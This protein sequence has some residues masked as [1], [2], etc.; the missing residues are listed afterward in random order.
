MYE[1]FT[2]K[3]LYL[4]YNIYSA[5]KIIMDRFHTIVRAEIVVPP[6]FS[7]LQKLHSSKMMKEKVSQEENVRLCVFKQCANRN[8]F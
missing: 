4:G 1:L 2:E 8:L 6:W 7:R 3:F 5:T